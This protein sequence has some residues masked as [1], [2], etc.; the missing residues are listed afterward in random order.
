MP[1]VPESVPSKAVTEK[2]APIQ[3]IPGQHVRIRSSGKTGD[4]STP[5]YREGIHD[6]IKKSL[7]AGR[8]L[9][10]PYLVLR[11]MMSDGFDFVVGSG[12][13]GM[14]DVMDEVIAAAPEFDLEPLSVKLFGT[15]EV[16]YKPR[17]LPLEDALKKE[18]PDI[19]DRIQIVGPTS[20]VILNDLDFARKKTLE[21]KVAKT[22]AN[23]LKVRSMMSMADRIVPLVQDKEYV[24]LVEIAA[25]LAGTDDERADPNG[26]FRKQIAEILKELEF[27]A[28]TMEV[29][30]K[31]T[32]VFRAPFAETGQP[33]LPA[34]PEETTGMKE[35]TEE[36][37]QEET[38]PLS[39]TPQNPQ[40]MVE[41]ESVPLDR[42]EL[43]AD[44][45]VK[46]QTFLQG[47]LSR[48]Y[49]S[50]EELILRAVGKIPQELGVSSRIQVSKYMSSLGLDSTVI[51]E[52]KVFHP[53]GN[54]PS[55][56]ELRSHFS[57][58]DREIMEVLDI[59]V[60]DAP[61]WMNE[62]QRVNLS[63]LEHASLLLCEEGTHTRSGLFPGHPSVDWQRR[64][65]GVFQSYGLVSVHGSA[66]FTTYSGVQPAIEQALDRDFL[67]GI[68]WKRETIRNEE[69]EEEKPEPE[70]AEPEPEKALSEAAKD[71]G[72]ETDLIKM[73]QDMFEALKNHAEEIRK[74]KKRVKQLE[75][76]KGLTDA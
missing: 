28:D 58:L 32:K 52:R 73:V 26:K 20:Y 75:G 8:Q 50:L 60:S 49:M 68:F 51:D 5:A 66:F 57:Q 70:K 45:K 23:L 11:V 21:A 7:V 44:W 15:T 4:A 41:D 34:E 55:E 53:E 43:P 72:E 13:K 56:E 54:A 69:V 33:P 19:F 39:E 14:I 2:T 38:I 76:G 62:S 17:G 3:Y 65:M 48:S 71:D 1:E 25:Q 64:A 16:I 12:P 61:P 6:S 47:S 27:T 63:Y 46:V 74:L 59:K 18:Y 24:T 10:S 37:I 9:I 30:G 31:R 40:D 35:Q 29:G 22:Q 67:L 36:D 42:K